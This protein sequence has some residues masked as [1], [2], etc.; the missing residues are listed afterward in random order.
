[1]FDIL[2]GLGLMGVG[3]VMIVWATKLTD[4]I[5]F[6]FGAKI[7]GG[8]SSAAYQLLGVLLI[9]L[10]FFFIFGFLKIFG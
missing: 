5:P 6:E 2:F 8:S 10:S 1:M 4:I 7:T 9:M 3:I